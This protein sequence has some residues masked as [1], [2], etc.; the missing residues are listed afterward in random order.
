MFNIAKQFVGYLMLCS[1][2]TNCRIK[3]NLVLTLKLFVEQTL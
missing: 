1:R 3:C 2:L